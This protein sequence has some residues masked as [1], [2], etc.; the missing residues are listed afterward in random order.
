[1]KGCGLEKNNEFLELFIVLKQH[2]PLGQYTPPSLSSHQREVWTEIQPLRMKSELRTMVINSI[3]R[4]K[5]EAASGATEY[6]W[7]YDLVLPSLSR[8]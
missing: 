2:D 8:G 4:R 7:S 5:T 1:M 6:L 3:R